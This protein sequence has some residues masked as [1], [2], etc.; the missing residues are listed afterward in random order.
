MVILLLAVSLTVQADDKKATA[1]SLPKLMNASPKQA[2]GLSEQANDLPKTMNRAVDWRKPEVWEQRA[3]KM[4]PNDSKL[5][6]KD[7]VVAADEGWNSYYMV[8]L[9]KPGSLII[10]GELV[11]WKPHADF[12]GTDIYVLFPSGIVNGRPGKFL[13]KIVWENKKWKYRYEGLEPGTYYL[14]DG[15]SMYPYN[16][17]D[18]KYSYTVHI[19]T[20]FEPETYV[21]DRAWERSNDTLK[22][23]QPVYEGQP[24]RGTTA[25]SYALTTDWVDHYGYT[26]PIESKV[27]IRCTFRDAPAYDQ[28]PSA[29]RAWFYDKDNP[30]SYGFYS[31]K[32][33]WK[34]QN[35]D[36]TIFLPRGYGVFRITGYRDPHLRHYP[37]AHE[38]R[39]D[40]IETYPDTPEP[41][42]LKSNYEDRVREG[43]TPMEEG[44]PVYATIGIN[45]EGGIKEGLC[46]CIDQYTFALD[47]CS[48]VKLSVVPYEHLTL[49]ETVFPVKMSLY[50]VP[51][52]TVAFTYQQEVPYVAG[53]FDAQGKSL[54]FDGVSEHVGYQYIYNLVPTWGFLREAELTDER[55]QTRYYKRLPPGQYKVFMRLEQPYAHQYPATAYTVKWEKT[56]THDLLP[57]PYEDKTEYAP[58]DKIEGVLGLYN[59]MPKQ[60]HTRKRMGDLIY[61]AQPL[62]G[63]LTVRL[64]AEGVRDDN[65]KDSIPGDYHM[66]AELV[67]DRGLEIHRKP[68]STFNCDTLITFSNLRAS[69]KYILYIGYRRT[70]MSYPNYF[71]KNYDVDGDYR[72]VHSYDGYVRYSVWLDPDPNSVGTTT[73]ADGTDDDKAVIY[74]PAGRRLDRMMQGVNIVRKRDGTARKVVVK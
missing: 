31:L 47:K 57:R 19:T 61:L 23:A 52:S 37:H 48:D 24:M 11:A 49:K 17:G 30:V 43:G 70:G 22:L 27:R 64:K 35:A 60:G 69:S 72:Y 34:T 20:E 39:Y 56:A 38:L 1:R 71:I 28:Y 10:T 65:L 40:V 63:N 33:S 41:N 18:G 6:H 73:A 66:I 25:Y 42:A 14:C 16:Q 45:P 15:I 53:P 2:N 21:D 55:E 36:T 26:L 9:D 3:L 67:N 51:D 4:A 8:T 68:V 32:S 5:Y 46:D 13:H 12:A 44:Q 50:Y 7:Y 62:E 54:R 29:E 58:G 59:Y 74:D